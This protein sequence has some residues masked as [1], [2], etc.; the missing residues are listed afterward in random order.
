[1][2]FHVFD[3][4]MSLTGLENDVINVSFCIPSHL[5]PQGLT[6]EPLEVAPVFFKLK[7]IQT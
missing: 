7:G 1:M 5:S 3:E 6:H 4:G 2:F